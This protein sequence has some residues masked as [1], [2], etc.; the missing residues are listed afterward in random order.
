MS[1]S[2]D[3]T[4]PSS[5]K[6]LDQSNP[7]SIDALSVEI[8]LEIFIRL[9]S[10]ATLIRAALTCRAWRRAVASSPSFRRRFRGLHP[11]PFLGIFEDH[12]IDALPPFGSAHCRDRDMLAAIRGGDFFLTP[13][14]EPGGYARDVP[15]RWR[16]QDCRGG[17]LLLLNLDAALLAIV[18]PLARMCPNF[19][20]SPFPKNPEARHLTLD[21]HLLSSDEK[22]KSFRIVW[23]VYE[24]S[25]VQVVIFSSDTGEWCFHPWVEIAERAPP[26]GADKY[27]L[28]CGFQA[29]GSLHWPFENDEHMLTLDTATMKF[30]VSEVPPYVK[31]LQ[32]CYHAIGETKNGATCMVFCIELSIGVLK[33]RFDDN[34]VE[35]W[36]LSGMVHYEAEPQQQMNDDK[37]RV[38]VIE[39]GFA[40]LTSTEMVLSLCLETM[41]LKELFPRY[42]CSRHF[43]PYIM[44]WPPSLV[45]NYGSFAAVQDGFSNA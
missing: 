24:K 15:L 23:L 26:L 21:L 6:S 17:Y 45:G 33:R 12:R 16:I 28:R 29:N 42:F 41:K 32:H 44:A 37:L 36:V 35:G 4:M 8:L 18:N 10:L 39:D 43:H 38:L 9:P 19:I 40:Y 34:G 27:W 5:V 11:A 22:P 31:G 13:L 20:V 30:S 25:R 2:G 7:A 14:L 3:P 1:R